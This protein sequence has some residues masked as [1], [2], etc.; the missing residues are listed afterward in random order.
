MSMPGYH[1]WR[2]AFAALA[3]IALLA[4]S[5]GCFNPFDPRIASTAVNATPPPAPDSPVGIVDLFQWCWRNRAYDSY[6]ELFTDNYRFEFA[7]GDSA[8]NLYRDAP[9]TRTDE[10]ATAQHLF[11]TGTPSQPPASSITLDWTQD[12]SVDVDARPGKTDT[13]YHRLITAQ[14]LLRVNLTDGTQEVR[15][16]VYF[17]V[18]RGDSAIIPPELIQRG[19]KPDS[20]RWYIERWVDG[21]LQSGAFAARPAP[22]ESARPSRRDPAAS[23]ALGAPGSRPRPR[24]GVPVFGTSWGALKVEFR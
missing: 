9:W 8:G 13:T 16:P 20:H 17:N 24:D 7:T 4:C 11:V 3:V 10:L 1:P 14:V 22:L 18:T 12:L 23:S 5:S 15:G 19:F 21:T 6:Q 2:A